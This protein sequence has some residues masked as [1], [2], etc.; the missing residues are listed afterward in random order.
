MATFGN[1][2]ANY[3]L[4]NAQ[5]SKNLAV[6][7]QIEGVDSLF[8]LAN[9]FTKV[10]YGDAGIV[11]G[12]PGLVYGAL[13]RVPNVKAYIQLDGLSIAQRI[14][15]EQGKG[16]LGTI[17]LSLIDYNGQV[18]LLIAPGVILDEIIAKR[19]I[20]VWLGFAQTS[21]PEDYLLVY[22][23]YCTQTITPPG[24]VKFQ[25]SDS[26]SKKRQ[27]IFVTSTT[28]LT[29]AINNSQTN[30][31]VV[32]TFGFH[33]QI[34]GPDGTY[35]PIVRTYLRIDDEAMEYG[36][37]GIT[38][39]TLFTVLSRGGSHSL[40]TTPASHD[41]DSTVS[42]GIQLGGNVAGE[43]CITLVLKILLSGW[44]G[45]C[46][47]GVSIVTFA[48]SGDTSAFQ[49]ASSLDAKIDLGLTVGDYFYITDAGNPSNDLNGII[50]GIVSLN[51]RDQI[52]QTDQTFVFETNSP[53]VVAFRSKYDT[54]PITAGAKCRMRDVDV[55]TLEMVRHLYFT[56]GTS[57]MQ[58]YYDSPMD[59]KEV[60][61]TD[62]FLPIGAY[63]ISRFGRISMSIAKPPLPGIGKLVELNWTNVLE[64]DKIT[65]T[66]ASNNRNFF[67]LITFEYDQDPISKSFET[68]EQFLD[69]NSLNLFNQT[70]VLPISAPGLK[71]A[72]G[73]KT[74]AE[75]RGR[76]LLNRYKNCAILINL[77]VNWSVG[78]LIEVSDIVLLRDEGHL[79]IMNY[80]T[81][82]RNLGVQLFEVINRN[83]N[84]PEGNVDLTVLGGLGFNVDSRFGL[85][86]PSSVIGAGS[87]SSNLVIIP[88][89]GQ[90]LLSNEVAKWAPFVGQKVFV[91]ST[92]YTTRSGQTTFVRFNTTN[93]ST[94]D[95]DPPLGFTPQAGDILDIPVY[96]NGTDK[97]EDATYKLL[98]AHQSPS[99]PVVTGLSSTQFTV[100]A[101]DVGKFT[102]GNVVIV[103]NADYSVQSN[104]IKVT[105]ITGVTITVASSLGFTPS[106]ANTVEGIGYHD[107]TA[108]YRYS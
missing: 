30:I 98:Y 85:Y 92:D 28:N 18:S 79:K 96:P 19:E 72:L 12:L 9:T 97:N 37:L 68:I 75:R 46:E 49:F 36:P 52:V 95:L 59:A 23:G 51:D 29:S 81:G 33:K 15:P 77:K 64:P 42:N 101:G 93:P 58:F 57:N 31:P 87:T 105:D 4:F 21:Y 27:P 44:D 48:P 41:I 99:V 25:V 74:I 54:L 56:S 69:T 107:G 32:S 53:A 45:P 20:R 106:S 1:Y 62:I 6:V 50:T 91:H 24:L 35:D 104:E 47:T 8:G 78:S 3:L 71:S 88:S 34:L 103:R 100:G 67:N 108:F 61:D 26:T 7:M 73:G 38:S 66:R 89:Y 40:G 14:E 94:L 2:P 70:S 39:D 55:E 11:Y 86:S 102:V 65:T 76:A 10:R 43:N 82:E 17:T 60:I 22:R 83:Y 5:Q 90:T 84:I 16:N 80:E 63:G 13:K